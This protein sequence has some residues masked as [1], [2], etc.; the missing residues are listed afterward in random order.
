MQF[1]GG[2]VSKM[3]AI[4]N[5]NVPVEFP[6]VDNFDEDLMVNIRLFILIIRHREMYVNLPRTR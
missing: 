3:K 1:L 6:S 4:A 2:K 5:P